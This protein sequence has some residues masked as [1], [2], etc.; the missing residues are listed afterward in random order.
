[1]VFTVIS[2]KNNVYFFRRI[3]PTT[4][5]RFSVAHI[6]CKSGCFSAFL[7]IWVEVSG[8][9]GLAGSPHRLPSNTQIPPGPINLFFFSFYSIARRFCLLFNII[10]RIFLFSFVMSLHSS[11]SFYL[12][13]I[14]HYD[15]SKYMTEVCI[16][17]QI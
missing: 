14:C 12:F 3:F 11:L 1:M 17:P 4:F 2:L 13:L 6:M 10:V 15:N 5:R 16:S 9:I 8:T 7:F